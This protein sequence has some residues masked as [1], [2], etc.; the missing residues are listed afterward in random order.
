MCW[1]VGVLANLG[2][3]G[4]LDVTILDK[5]PPFLVLCIFEDVVGCILPRLVS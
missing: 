3:E 2:Y 5:A 4:S 1:C